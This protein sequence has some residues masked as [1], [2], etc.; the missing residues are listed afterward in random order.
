VSTISLTLSLK[1]FLFTE[2]I[3]KSASNAKDERNEIMEV[4]RNKQTK[5]QRYKYVVRFFFANDEQIR[6]IG[7]HLS[8]GLFVSKVCSHLDI[9]FYSFLSSFL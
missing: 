2:N 6:E 5:Q 9:N 1:T 8:G 3:R 4:Q 7:N